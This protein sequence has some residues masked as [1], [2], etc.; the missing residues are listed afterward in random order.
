MIKKLASCI[1]EYRWFAAVTPLLMLG[2]VYFEI[3]IPYYM[4]DLID[5]GIEAGNM[6]E[7]ESIGLRLA[8]MAVCSM[9]CGSL[10]AVTAARASAGFASN[11]R[12][13]MFSRIQRFSF[14]NIDHISGSGLVTRLTTDVTNVQMA[15]GML[16]RMAFRA[17]A[18]MIFA[19]MMVY[20]INRQLAGVILAA[21]PV[22]AVGMVLI[23]T[24]AFKWFRRMFDLY[25]KLNS[26]VQENIRGIKVVKAFVRER[27]EIGKFT[28]VAN[29]VYN[30]NMKAET[31]MAFMSPLMNTVLYGCMLV[32]SWLGAK[33]IVSG[34]LTTGLL[35]SFINY[36]MQV[37]MSLMMLSGII[38][39]ITMSGAAAKRI[40][41]VFDEVPE[42][43]DCED[44]VFEIADGSVRFE[45]VSFGYGSGADCLS[46]IDLDIPAGSTVGIIGGTGSGKTSL[47]QLI[48]RLYDA[49][50]G[51]VLVGG[52]DVRE[53]DLTALRK[54]AA[55]VLQKN[56]LFSGTVEDNLRWGREDATEEEM[57]EALDAAQAGFV[58]GFEGGLDYWIEQGGGNV[59]GGQRQRLCI[60]RA[61]IAQPKILI[62]DDSTSAVDTHTESL[63]REKLSS[64]SG[65]TKI[66]IAQRISSVQD[67]DMIVVLDDGRINGVGTHEELLAGNEIYREVYESQNKGG[68]FDEPH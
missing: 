40:A 62:L 17:P 47:V 42:I 8:V 53:L 4:A 60:A 45:D 39:M 67:A 48:P 7:I 34:A 68:D 57:W 15:F 14:A 21:L 13:D 44:P 37:L 64:L 30:T 1:R 20:R 18:T 52:T 29:D 25:D 43:V 59:S 38:V 9:A 33:L 56:V 24:G 6:A 16:L 3:M 10:A 11:L 63:I 31:I 54:S 49:R 32:I 50:S 28:G 41:E 23:I 36:V 22:L 58:R 66:I 55:M 65:M 2:E 12:S 35:M 51:R 26:V 46:G 61:L 19:G 27:D 5:L